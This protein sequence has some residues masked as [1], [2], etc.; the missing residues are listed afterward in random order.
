T[1]REVGDMMDHM[2]DVQFLADGWF[3]YP[4]ERNRQDWYNLGGFAKVQ[5]Y[6][7]R[8]IE[9]YALRDD[10][11]PFIRSYFNT[12]PSLLGMETL[13]FNEH[14]AGVAA[15]NKT[16]ETG[17]FLFYSRLMRVQ[18]RGDELWLMP[19][20]PTDWFKDGA[21]ISVKNAPT[22]FGP[23]SY[24]AVSHLSDGY[25]DV[26]VTCPTREKPRRIAVRVRHPEG[27]AIAAASVEAGPP[28][29]EAIGGLHPQDRSVFYVEASAPTVRVRA[30]FR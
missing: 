29:A 26:R 13:S 24:E 25:V 9:I 16:H 12:I 20:V 17:Y 4:A 2:E 10:V 8:N 1:S 6:Y 22:R 28:D 23:V 5:P 14:F 19:F 27:K 7:C 18:E 15:W 30:Q 11:K 3:D 21:R